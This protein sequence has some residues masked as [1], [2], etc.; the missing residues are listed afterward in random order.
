[1]IILLIIILIIRLCFEHED[2][3]YAVF[4]VY[5]IILIMS[6]KGDTEEISFNICIQWR[7]LQSN[8]VFT[9][10]FDQWYEMLY[11]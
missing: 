5:N 4:V 7:V 1:M 6:E 2:N 10:V 9:L 3:V 11:Y 8:V